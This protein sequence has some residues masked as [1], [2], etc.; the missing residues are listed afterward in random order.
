MVG[1]LT[2]RLLSGVGSRPRAHARAVATAIYEL[3]R[4]LGTA[5]GTEPVTRGADCERGPG[6][7]RRLDGQ[8]CAQ[9]TPL[10]AIQLHPP[11][12]IQGTTPTLVARG[13]RH[14]IPIDDGSGRDTSRG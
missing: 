9:L 10:E 14:R 1:W 5:P 13:A 11:P 8:Q 4:L 7:A 12:L 3:V 6:R 2:T